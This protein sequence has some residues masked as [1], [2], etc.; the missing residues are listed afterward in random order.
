MLP[1]KAWLAKFV[2]INPKFSDA[3]GDDGSILLLAEEDIARVVEE[4]VKVKGVF[5]G[6]EVLA[7]ATKASVVDT[8][9]KASDNNK[10]PFM[11]GERTV[12]L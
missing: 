3:G 8:M 9:A 6:N 5:I 4:G 10:R 7:L 11:M 1:I 2:P 12:A